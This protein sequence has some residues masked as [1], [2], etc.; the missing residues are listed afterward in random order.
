M[1]T[2]HDRAQLLFRDAISASAKAEATRDAHL[3]SLHRVKAAKDKA[4]LALAAK[5][6]LDALAKLKRD[7]AA[8]K[9]EGLVTKALRAVFGRDDYEFKFRWDS[10]RG[11][12]VAEPVLISHHMGEEI[13][14]DLLDGRGGGI[15]DV[16]SFALRF[17]VARY[18]R[19]ALRPLML[20]DEMFKHVS[21]NHAEGVAHLLRTLAK[22]TGWS[23][24]LVTHSEEIADGAD[25][26]YR[27]EKG[28]DGR[29]AFTEEPA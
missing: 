28:E 20:C 13:E 27:A 23:I 10:K 26:V 22:K 14:T 8:K 12:A 1:A 17:I 7:E 2:I 3:A 29:T 5:D 15:V 21:K 18:T 19:P 6:A 16:A 9:I 11:V 4:D 24:I 25:K